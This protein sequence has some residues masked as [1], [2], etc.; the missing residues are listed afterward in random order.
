MW[1]SGYNVS[2][3]LITPPKDTDVVMVAPRM[4]GNMVRELFEHDKGAMA[5]VAVQQ[6][7]SG[8]ARETMMALAKGIGC[9]R[10]GVFESSFREEAEMDLFAEQVVWSGLV[11]WFEEC[12][13]LGVEQG[14]SPE[15][16][17]LELYASG[18]AAEILGMMGRRGFYKQMAHHSTT[19]Q[20]GTLSRAQ[21]LL[22]DELR[23]K[24]RDLFIK[25]IKEGAFVKE[26]SSEQAGG[27]KVLA[28][29]K[30]EAMKSPMSQAEDRII[31][32][33]QKAHSLD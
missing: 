26:W 3:D 8:K 1:A 21:G 22:G 14:F 15:L 13:K 17:V 5:Q 18:E 2:Y 9:T 28:R 12:F 24:M 33:V 31:P 29:L 30:E 11:A 27:S 25:D 32:I 16:M 6:D 19:S 4:T 10:G 23:Q 7:F 20:Y